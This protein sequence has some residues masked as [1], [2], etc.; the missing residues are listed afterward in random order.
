[1]ALK[2]RKEMDSRYQWDLSHIYPSAEAW[3][4][5]YAEA[6]ALTDRIPALAGTLGASADSLFK[7]P[8]HHCRG[9]AGGGACLSLR[10]AQ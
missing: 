6:E 7:R 8:E 2:N 9:V 3:E 10:V 4:K 1:M 5:A